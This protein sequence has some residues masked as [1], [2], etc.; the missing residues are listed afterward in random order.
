LHAE[1]ALK[2]LGLEQG[3]TPDEI[4]QAYRDLVKVWHPDRFGSD[5]R[6]RSKAGGSAQASH[7]RLPLVG[8]R[9]SRIHRHSSIPVSATASIRTYQ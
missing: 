4:K 8:S 3:A 7:F 9:G 5:V 6:L 1:E 2:I